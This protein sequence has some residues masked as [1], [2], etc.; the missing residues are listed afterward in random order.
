MM[1]VDPIRRV[2]APRFIGGVYLHADSGADFLCRGHHWCWMVGVL[3]IGTDNGAFWSQ[4]E[5]A[6]D[7]FSDICNGFVK[8]VVFGA[9]VTLI[10]TLSRLGITPDRRTALLVR[11]LRRSWF[12]LFL[13]SGSISL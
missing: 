4:M 5:S 1:G 12:P 7:V 10:V 13:F 8:S 6:V 3:L 11:P 9:A 2:F